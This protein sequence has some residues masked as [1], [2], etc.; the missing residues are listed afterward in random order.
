MAGRAQELDEDD[1]FGFVLHRHR[2]AGD[3]NRGAEFIGAQQHGA[4]DT[5]AE[6]L[7]ELTAGGMRAPVERRVAVRILFD[8]A[9][10][11]GLFVHAA[12]PANN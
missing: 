10:E 8:E 12:P 9:I 11:F 3:V 6:E 5:G 4:A 2:R 7:E 1:V